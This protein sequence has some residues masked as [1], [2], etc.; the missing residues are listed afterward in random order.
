MPI[1]DSVYNIN[2]VLFI[3]ACKFIFKRILV[4]NGAF[5][6]YEPRVLLFIKKK[7]AISYFLVKRAHKN[8]TP[9]PL[10]VGM[11]VINILKFCL[12]WRTEYLS[13]QLLYLLIFINLSEL[14][15]ELFRKK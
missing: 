15:S 8:F 13:V 2:S 10:Q 12:Q 1:T 3:N 4:Q 9:L 7:T 5:C 6:Q 11:Y 14:V